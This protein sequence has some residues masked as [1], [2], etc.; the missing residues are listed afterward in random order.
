MAERTY[1]NGDELFHIDSRP[2]DFNVCDFWHF[3][4]G[5]LLDNTYRGHLAEFIV[6]KALGLDTT[7]PRADWSEYDLFYRETRIEV[8]SSAYL[9]SW[10]LDNEKYSSIRF[11]VASAR[12]YDATSGGYSGKKIRHSDVYV[13][14]VY[15]ERNKDGYDIIDLS[16]WSFYLL[17][18]AL[19]NQTYGERRT[20]SLSALQKCGAVQCSYEEIKGA[21]DHMLAN[22]KN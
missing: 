10:N 13:F 19:L 21:L 2:Q 15:E 17:P 3:A 6:S 18:T 14:C 7:T 1:H 11:S 5:D 16:K 4:F 22:R 20:L 12:R 9:Q 8:K